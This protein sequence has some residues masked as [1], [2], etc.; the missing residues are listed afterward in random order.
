MVQLKE[1]VFAHWLDCVTIDKML[2]FSESQ[3][4]HL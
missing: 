2:H 3:F 1:Q 4:A